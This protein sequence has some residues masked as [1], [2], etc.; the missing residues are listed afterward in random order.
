LP[1]AKPN[2]LELIWSVASFALGATLTL[3]GNK[4][5]AVLGEGQK[6]KGNRKTKIFMHWNFT[7]SSQN[8]NDSVFYSHL[9]LR[10]VF[11]W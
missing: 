11:R 8:L 1:Q 4:L 3:G 9:K 5:W 10:Q 7:K 2:R 6:R